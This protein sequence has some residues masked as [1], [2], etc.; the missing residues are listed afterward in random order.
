[1]STSYK[2]IKIDFQ[3]PVATVVFNR[4]DQLN[5]MNRT[6]M[7]EIIHA[8]DHIN[9]LQEIKVGIFTGAGRAFMA[10]A[11]IKEYG[12]QTPEQFKSFQILGTSLYHKVETAP[13]PWL[14]AINGIAL[15][16]GF[17]IALACDMI[18]AS[19]QASM[20]LP[21]VF[22]NLIPGGGA[23]QRLIQKIGVNRA[24]EM[25]FL[26]SSMGAGT[27]YEWGIVNHLVKEVD[28]GA[29]VYKFALKLAR[30]PEKSLQHLKRLANLSLT[31]MPFEQRLADEGNTVYKLFFDEMAQKCIKDFI[32]KNQKK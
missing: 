21:E 18:L 12:R 29:E 4:P 22:L 26:G 28:F 15:G 20:G 9:A 25:L 2:T 27:L 17:E 13:K 32:N 23:T 19:E 31:N 1:M 14:A 8:I 10:G 11:D 7:E 16:G 5:A 3:G 6:M 30:R 24:K